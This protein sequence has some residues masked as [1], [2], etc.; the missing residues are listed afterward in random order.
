MRAHKQNME[1]LPLGCLE[2]GREW[3]PLSPVQCWE[4]L[5]P[6]LRGQWSCLRTL[7][8]LAGPCPQEDVGTQVGRCWLL[9]LQIEPPDFSA[10]S[11]DSLTEQTKIRSLS[12]KAGIVPGEALTLL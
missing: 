1:Q 7:G 11:P 3:Q 9:K 12:C 5:S 8:G 4:Q 2:L 6:E 10:A